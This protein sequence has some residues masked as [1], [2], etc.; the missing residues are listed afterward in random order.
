MTNDVVSERCG[1]RR[2][3][4]ESVFLQMSQKI[5]HLELDSQ[6]KPNAF[7]LLTHCDA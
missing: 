7:D 5:D 2:C 6:I 3:I 1:S 4:I